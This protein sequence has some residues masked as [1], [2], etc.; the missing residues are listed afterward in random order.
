METWKSPPLLEL[1]LPA[2]PQAVPGA[3]HKAMQACIEAGLTDDDC[4]TLDLALGEALANAVMHGAP[5]SL[6]ADLSET[7][8]ASHVCLSLWG[9]QDRLIIQVCD[10][11]PGFDPPP[12]P[13]PMPNAAWE[14]THGRGLPLMETLTD[15]M[16]VCRGGI[17]EG[18][19]CVYLVKKKARPV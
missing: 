6:D 13:Y 2:D 14:T 15:A 11:G 16:V 3:R 7:K 8:D 4:F 19:A 1:W 18:G 9:Y 17:D 10:R 12:P 5:D